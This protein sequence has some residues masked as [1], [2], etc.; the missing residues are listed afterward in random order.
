MHFLLGQCAYSDEI[1]WQDV[2]IFL[3]IKK[4]T[5]KFTKNQT[6]FYITAEL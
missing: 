6:L 1:K 3:K 2:G 4:N 5:P